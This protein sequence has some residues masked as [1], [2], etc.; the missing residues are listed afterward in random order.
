[1]GMAKKIYRFKCMKKIIFL[2]LSLIFLNSCNAQKIN[3]MEKFDLNLLANNFTNEK[4]VTIK[5]DEKIRRIGENENFYFEIDSSSNSPY[6]EKKYYSKR[7]LNLISI[8]KYFYG[9]PIGIHTTYDDEGN[10]IVEKDMEN[11]KNFTIKQLIDKVDSEFKLDLLN[12]TDKGI[13]MGSVGNILVYEIKIQKKNN[14]IEPIRVIK[15]SAIDG[16]TIS[17]QKFNFEK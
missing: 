15:I 8:G 2:K 4:I 13:S 3:K 16:E 6:Q 14:F 9:I 1:M 10:K 7:T 5:N 12:A 17:D 11:D